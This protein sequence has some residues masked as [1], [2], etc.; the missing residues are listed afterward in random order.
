MSYQIGDRVIDE[1]GY[2]GVVGIFWDDGD[3]CTVE[4]DA[5]H[6]N[7]KK[8][9]RVVYLFRCDVCRHLFITDHDAHKHLNRTCPHCGSGKYKEVKK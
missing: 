1:D 3:F 5:A 4:N 6:P 9:P 8:L 2:I 7:P